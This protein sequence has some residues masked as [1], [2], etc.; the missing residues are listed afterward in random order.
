VVP[1][2]NEAQRQ[3]HDEQALRDVAQ[4]ECEAQETIR[5]AEQ[6]GRGIVAGARAH[7][8]LTMTAAREQVERKLDDAVA[9]VACLV[10]FGDTRVVLDQVLRR[11][12]H[13]LAL[14]GDKAEKVR[15]VWCL[16]LALKWTARR[17]SAQ[18]NIFVP[19]YKDILPYI[20]EML[21]EKRAD[22]CS[23]SSGPGRRPTRDRFALLI[24]QGVPHDRS[25]IGSQ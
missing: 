2:S 5:D 21:E 23:G 16:A 12:R 22:S 19:S 4:M 10:T 8:D 9:Y 14:M 1:E 11:W 20:A 18:E 25:G 15:T 7:R 6:Q 24:D 17:G 13:A 3:P